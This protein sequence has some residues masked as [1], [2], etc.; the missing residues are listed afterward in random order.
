ML[1]YILF[2]LVDAQNFTFVTSRK[3]FSHSCLR[4]QQY[5]AVCYSLMSVWT[6]QWP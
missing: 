3:K 4:I 1:L 2:L 6:R 5:L